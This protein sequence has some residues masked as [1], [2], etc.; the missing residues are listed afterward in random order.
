MVSFHIFFA[1]IFFLLFTQVF[2][3]VKFDVVIIP[4][5]DVIVVVVIIVIV[6]VIVILD[7]TSV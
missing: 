4:R 1:Y 5:A 7:E 6:I 3:N 2:I